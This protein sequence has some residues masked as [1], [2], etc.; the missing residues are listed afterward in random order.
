MPRK[1]VL[2]RSLKKRAEALLSENRLPEAAELYAKVCNTD[3][4]DTDA[5]VMYAIVQMRQG[6]L[7]SAEATCLHAL[8]IDPS[9]ALA[10]HA[11]GSAFE[12]QDRLDEALTEFQRAISLRPDFANAHLFLANTLARR[13]E[14]SEAES[15]HLKA[16][17][18]APDF[19]Q[20]MASLGAMYINTA[21]FG[22][23]EDWLKKAL[24][25]E[26]GNTEILINLGQALVSQGKD[27]EA[28][29]VLERAVQSDPGS[30]RANYALG[31]ILTKTGQYSHAMQCYKKAASI[32]PDDEYALGA[33]AHVLERRGELEEALSLLK[34]FVESGSTHEGVVLP[35]AEL[36]LQLG[37]HDEA[38]RL[39]EQALSR[40]ALDQ[41]TCTEIH[42]KLGKLLDSAGNY[43]RSFEHYRKA[44]EISRRVV[45]QV[46]GVD[47]I[48]AQAERIA[49]RVKTCGRDLWDAFPRAN[50]SSER[51]VFVVGMP[52]SG[53]T[54]VEQILASHPEVHGAGELQ[55]MEEIA[56]SLCPGNGYQ[57]SYPGGLADVSEQALEKHAARHLHQLDVLSGAAARVVD[58][59]PHNFMHLGLISLL[60]PRAHIIH[61]A[62]EPLDTCSSIYF[63]LFTPLHA[64]ACDLTRLGQYYRIYQKLMQYWNNVLSIPILNIQ[65]ENLVAEPE[66]VSRSLVEFCGLDWDDR[67]LEFYATKRD[68]NTPSYGQVR[69]PIYTKSVSRWKNYQA[70]LRPLMD[71]LNNQEQ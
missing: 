40:N 5:W 10:H 71:A 33:Q 56:R 44:N 1:N 27:G 66:Q 30:Y 4:T 9:H 63:Q 17:K 67:C 45:T 34:P 35:F 38:I 62:R 3:K 65:Y 46:K 12:R 16:L 64:Y 32:Q 70:H 19:V 15:C 25:T 7:K 37:N 52:R 11:L 24:G 69:Q 47:T 23:A 2:T 51:P 6:D 21:R 50:N 18:L 42:Y 31:N 8:K 13:G 58:K 41:Q 59:C 57:L 20:A 36:S 43:D 53:T 29:Q 54:L 68:V 61:I 60:Y 14:Y 22:E 48:D 28:L 39:L 55:A 49:Q 26:P